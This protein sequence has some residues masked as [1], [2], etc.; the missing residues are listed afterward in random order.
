MTAFDVFVPVHLDLA[1]GAPPREAP[2]P[3]P[4]PRDPRPD[5]APP[6]DFVWPATNLP[7]IRVTD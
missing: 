1:A 3:E 4:Q 6:K 5:Q 7:G 2:T